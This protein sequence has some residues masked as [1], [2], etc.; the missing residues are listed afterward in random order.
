MNLFT[1]DVPIDGSAWMAK[2]RSKQQDEEEEFKRKQEEEQERTKQKKNERRKS[3]LQ[4]LKVR[5]AVNGIFCFCFFGNPW[6]ALFPHHLFMYL[7]ISSDNN[8]LAPKCLKSTTT[9]QSQSL[10]TIY[11]TDTLIIEYPIVYEG[12]GQNNG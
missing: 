12:G 11:Y 3:Q 2:R 7:F 1:D 8:L 4:A 5:A 6:I 9:R 10:T